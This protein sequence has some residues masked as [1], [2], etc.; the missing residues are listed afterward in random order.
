ML[1]KP[2]YVTSL[3]FLMT[4]LILS[5]PAFAI[6]EGDSFE[7]VRIIAEKPP[8]YVIRKEETFEI[9][10]LGM[11][12]GKND[13][14]FT[15]ETGK[16]YILFTLLSEENE[17]FLAPQSRIT[18]G[19]RI[20][21]SEMIEYHI[22]LISGKLRAR[23]RIAQGMSVRVNT[24]VAEMLTNEA[25]FIVENQRGLTS[26][27][28]ISGMVTLVSA[29]TDQ[30]VGVPEQMMSSVGRNTPIYQLTSMVSNFYEGVEVS[31]REKTD[32]VLALIKKRSE[33][34]AEEKRKLDKYRKQE[35][36]HQDYVQHKADIQKQTDIQPQTDIQINAPQDSHSIQL[37]KKPEEKLKEQK[38]ELVQKVE[39]TPV[40]ITQ[41]TKKAEEE[42]QGFISKHKWHITASSIFLVSFWLSS[43]EISAY[44]SLDSDNSSL[45]SQYA[46][47]SV[48]ER[49]QLE[50]DFEVNKEKM[51]QHKENMELYNM[52]GYAALL[53][54]SYLLYLW[55]FDS[56]NETPSEKQTRSNI[57]PTNIQLVSNHQLP[58]PS[59]RLSATWNW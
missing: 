52:V 10:D 45:Q 36:E 57:W 24:T 8:V 58:N 14:I 55:Y 40:Q 27:G 15:G 23:V 29:K 32:D 25:E 31:E 26:V 47:A 21:S 1:R 2:Q 33:A 38:P 17:V 13:I 18:I 54:E 48:S 59:I 9:S 6:Q 16:A 11:I 30:R 3:F 46:S 20:I 7:T 5:G 37:E 42:E 41:L 39:K 49:T 12:L 44:K 28:T 22:N 53:W 4:I 35:A 50:I 34:A 43:N 19:K 51:K 56:D